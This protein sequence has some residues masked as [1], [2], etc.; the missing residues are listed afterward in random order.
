MGRDTEPEKIGVCLI[1]KRVPALVLIVLSL[2]FACDLA[3]QQTKLPFQ[4]ERAIATQ[5]FAGKFC[6]VHARAGAIPATSEQSVPTVVMTLQKLQLSGSDVFY[7]L[8]QMCTTDGAKS[9]TL[10]VEQLAFGRNRFEFDGRQ[11]LEITVCDFTP[12]WHANTGRLLGIGHTV[13][14]E[15]N[16]VRHLRPRATAYAVYDPERSVW[17]QWK[18]LE[19]PSD[20]KFSNAGAG[21]VQRL[22]LENGDILLPIYFKEIGKTQY[23]TTVLRCEFDGE[24][25]RYVEH[26]NELTARVKRG[27]YE[28]SLTELDGRWFLTMRNDDHGYVAVSEGSGSLKFSQPKKWIFDDG[29]DLGNYNTQQHWMRHPRHGLWLVYTRRNAD[30]DHVFRHRAP[31]FVARVD[32]EKLHVIRA[33]EQILIPEMGARL[34]NFGITEI[35]EKQTWVTVAEWMQGPGPNYQ[36]SAPIVERGADNRIWVAKVNW[37]AKPKPRIQRYG[38]EFMGAAV[39]VDHAALAHTAQFVAGDGQHNSLQ[40]EFQD[41][42]EQ[43][44]VALADVRSTRA[45]LVKLNLYVADSNVRKA[46]M[47]FLASW[48]S[49]KS[50]PAVSIV[51]TSLPQDR[52]FGLDAVFVARYVEKPGKVVHLSAEG[53][54]KQA[55]GERAR[56]SILP[57]GDVVYVSGKADPGDL[58]TAT[59]VTLEGILDILEGM[60]LDRSDIVQLKCFL[61]PMLQVDVVDRE[62]RAIFDEEIIPAVSHVEWLQGGSKPIEIETIVAAPSTK[63]SETISYYTPPGTKASPIFSRVARIH[64]DRRIYISGLIA[65]E[66]GNGAEQTHSI[67]QQMIRLLKPAGSNLRHLAKATYYVSDADASTELNKIRP[68]Y[69]DPQ[70][71]PAASKAKIRAT[72]FPDRTLAVDMIAAP[73]GPLISVLDSAAAALKPTRSVV[74]KT[75]EDRDLHLHIFEPDG[76]Q[77]SDHRSAFLAIHGGGWTGGNAESFYP[78]AAHFAKLGMIGIS[79]EYRLRNKTDETTVFDCVQDARSAVRWIRQHAEELGVNPKG[80][81][82]M[83]GSAGG[84]LAVSTALF[85]QVNAATDDTRRSAQPNALILMYP[86][87]DTSS[88]GYGQEK[89]GKRWQELSPVHNVRGDLPPTLIFH[90]TADAVTPYV[91]IEEFQKRSTAAENESILITQ[92]GGRHGYIIFDPDHYRLALQQMQEFLKQRQFLPQE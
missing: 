71:P 52:R 33:T 75:V 60:N 80:I 11:D 47:Q 88:A 92:P 27:L 4:I 1:M 30:N 49:D 44:S 85:E 74:Y 86:V 24:T 70:R 13:V 16:R 55:S 61:N 34:G 14:Y 38:T 25:L 23:S 77:S 57:Q 64:G 40:Q 76:H 58:A 65:N 84:H 68:H 42:F 89:M 31:L 63:T 48:C 29:E 45:D 73:E 36:D 87:I 32:P 59:R 17:P 7:A 5:G 39:L 62:I 51:A 3:A 54:Q 67:F 18:I 90:G 15:N 79:L 8:N 26:G 10:P 20:K 50:K 82:A 46:A 72:G 69:Y 78:F 53:G 81:V 6:W 28:P 35:S 41:V 43:L 9:W 12:K 37:A 21:S 83:G 66:A 22:D 19:M 91:G 2:I 56:V